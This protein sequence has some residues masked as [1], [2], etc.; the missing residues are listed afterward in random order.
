MSAIP[1]STAGDASGAEP[2][3]WVKWS[4]ICA[5]RASLTKERIRPP[6]VLPGLIARRSPRVEGRSRLASPSRSRIEPTDLQK[7]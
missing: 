5:T 6:A 7:K 4:S 3:Y 1:H 2:T